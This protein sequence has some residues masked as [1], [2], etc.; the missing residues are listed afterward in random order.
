MEK[1]QVNKKLICMTPVKN[2]RWILE[3]FLTSASEWA[4]HIIIADQ[5]STDG[6]LEIAKLHPKVTVVENHSNSFNE[7]ERQKLLI[8]TA[9]T[10]GTSNILI[11][12]DADE[13]FTANFS[14]TSDWKRL[15]SLTP[16]TTI[17]FRWVNLLPGAKRYWSPTK[18]HAWGYVDDGQLH[19]GKV[20]HS[21]R[22]PVSQNIVDFDEIRILH[23]QYIDWDRMESKQRWYMAWETLH[24][25]ANSSVQLYRMYSHMYSYNNNKISPTIS[26]WLYSHQ[27]Y[28]KKFSNPDA[29]YWWDDEVLDMFD[30]HGLDIFSNAP[31]WDRSWFDAAIHRRNGKETDYIDPR[32]FGQK[33]LQRWLVQ[34]RN[35]KNPKLVRIFDLM[36]RALGF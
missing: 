27:T 14:E 3:S 35:P 34:S 28:D 22:V 19:E 25:N 12:L 29:G 9:R 20:I 17:R 32:S 24:N 4:D 36:L 23:Y 8:D 30:Q 10:F 13:A 31:I 1:A 21:P 33:L 2:E 16:G 6:S 11:A 18:H 7:P 15:Q 26:G 5:G